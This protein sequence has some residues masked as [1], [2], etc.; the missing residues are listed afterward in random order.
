MNSAKMNRLYAIV[1]LLAAMPA[2]AQEKGYEP[3]PERVNIQA[4][5]AR[6]SQVID[7]E[8]VAVGIRKPEA[9]G[10]DH[11][12]MYAG[13]PSYRFT[14]GRDDN[15][16]EGYAP[17]ETKGR[18]ELSWC[19][20]TAADF[21]ALP[22]KTYTDAQRMKTVYHHGKGICP[23]GTSWS[24]TFSVRSPSELSPEVSTIFAQWHGMP[25]RTLVT[26]PDGRV[27]KLPAEEFL[28]MQD[29]VV[30]KKDTAYERVETT[31]RKGNKVWKA[32]KPTGWKVEQG[33]YP[34]LAF[35]FSGGYFYIKANSDRRWFTDKTDRCNANAAKARVMEPVTSE[36]KASTIA[37]R[38]PFEEF[39]KERWVTFTVEIDWTQYGGEAETI[40]RPGRLDV[41]MTCD[42]R[43]DHLVNDE[44]ILIGRNDE[45]GYYFKFGIYRVGDST[46]PVSYNLAGYSQRQR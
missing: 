36:F 33:G 13:K 11:T 21:A 41:R 35:G 15:T 40:V 32:G 1:L 46:E 5:S 17:G 14:L 3:L 12:R 8:W 9:L 38:M 4:D 28:A 42:G 19:Y 18:S 2:T 26:A 10:R 6:M 29:T 24:Y 39:P 45:D 37:A 31:D 7:G 25:D 20:A 30:I 34:P 16:L 27:M 44:Q 22:D 43:T 23:Q